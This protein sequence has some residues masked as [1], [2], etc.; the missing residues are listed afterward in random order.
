MQA[1]LPVR[2]SSLGEEAKAAGVPWYWVPGKERFT[3][4]TLP[5]DAPGSGTVFPVKNKFVPKGPNDGMCCFGYKRPGGRTHSGVDL[6]ARHLDPIYAVASGRVIS[7]YYYFDGTFALFVDHG[8]YVVNYG[9]CDPS[10]LT[11]CQLMAEYTNT[12]ERRTLISTN[13]KGTTVSAGDKIALVGRLNSGSSMLHFEMYQAGTKWNKNWN[14][15]PS[16]AAPGAFY[17]PTNFLLALAGKKTITP[18]EY[19][20]AVCR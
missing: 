1:S 2:T 16:T 15:F 20:P 8:D 7:F 6:F 13:K 5:S 10:S 14:G 11:E 19:V 3:K 9:E 12:Y 17:N 18:E 4:A